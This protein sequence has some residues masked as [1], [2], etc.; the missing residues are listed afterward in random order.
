MKIIC[1]IILLQMLDIRS[2]IYC[3]IEGA[4][5]RHGSKEK[6]EHQKLLHNLKR[7]RKAVK[8]EIEK[9]TAY[10]ARQKLKEQLER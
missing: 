8:R 1:L 7:E 6:L 3:S 9:D 4:K 2:S 5:K 10:L